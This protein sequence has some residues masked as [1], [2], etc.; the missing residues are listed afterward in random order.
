MEVPNEPLS[1]AKVPVKKLLT[2]ANKD[3][4]LDFLGLAFYR[5]MEQAIKNQYGKFTLAHLKKTIAEDPS[6]VNK[7]QNS[8]VFKK[9]YLQYVNKYNES[10]S[11]KGMQQK[12]DHQLATK[13]MN[14]AK[15]QYV[16]CLATKIQPETYESC[17][18]LYNDPVAQYDKYKI[19]PYNALKQK[20]YEQ[21]L[22]VHNT[23]NAKVLKLTDKAKISYLPKGIRQYIDSHP[24]EFSDYLYE[25]KSEAQYLDAIRKAMRNEKDINQR[26][27]V[28][29]QLMD[30]INRKAIES[31]ETESDTEEME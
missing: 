12:A 31:S 8:D 10:K 11:E 2:Y 7:L 4:L 29:R 25:I 26:E 5:T 27:H 13:L 14:K 22:A 23:K 18:S 20:Q 19:V 30:I 15:R 1:P 28:R 3:D 21:E 9:L 6:L 17:L 16:G 24:E